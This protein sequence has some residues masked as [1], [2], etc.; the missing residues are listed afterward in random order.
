MHTAA[1]ACQK[2]IKVL[3]QIGKYYRINDVKL[4]Y[5][6]YNISSYSSSKE[7]LA[8]I[9]FLMPMAIICVYLQSMLYSLFLQ[10]NKFEKIDFVKSWCYD[11]I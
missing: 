7:K 4:K 11:I 2:N 6:D 1:Y 8:L 10:W 9:I 5:K 3:W